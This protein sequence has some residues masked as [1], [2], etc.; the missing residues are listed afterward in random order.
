MVEQNYFSKEKLEHAPKSGFRSRDGFLTYSAIRA[1]GLQRPLTSAR[2]AP[3]PAVLRHSQGTSGFV[4]FSSH[5]SGLLYYFNLPI[6]STSIS[7]EPETTSHYPTPAAAFSELAPLN[8]RITG[9]EVEPCRE[10]S[11]GLDCDD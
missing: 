6:H 5:P 10:G 3:H 4:F 2:R 11:G 1:R 9:T 7:V 8:L